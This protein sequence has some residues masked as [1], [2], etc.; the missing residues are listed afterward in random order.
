RDDEG[1]VHT[2]TL[3]PYFIAKHPMTQ[4]QWLHAAGWNPSYFRP[5][6]HPGADL[7]YP[8][9]CVSWDECREIFDSLELELPTEAQWE[10]AARAGTTTMWWTGND[11]EAVLRI[12][13]MASTGP[14]PVG[15]FPA[16]NAFGLYDV[17]GNVWEW[18]RDRYGPLTGPGR[19]GG[20][21][22]LAGQREQTLSAR[23]RA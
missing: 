9:E 23:R 2:V 18:C 8:V 11:P 7:R 10:H 1:P 21:E 13:N 12:A 20:G 3:D 6:Q 4:S 15:H 16:P 19:P 5:D 17:I 14:T 22:R